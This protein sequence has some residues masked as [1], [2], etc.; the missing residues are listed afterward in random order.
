MFNVS[1]GLTSALLCHG[2]FLAA[3][4]VHK[5]VSVDFTASFRYNIEDF[6]FDVDWN[7][8][9]VRSV[10]TFPGQCCCSL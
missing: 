3:E 1:Y 2:H 7:S 6:V 8:T 10:S 9:I 5:S 4:N